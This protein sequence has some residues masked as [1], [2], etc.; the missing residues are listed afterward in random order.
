MK[1]FIFLF[2]TT[3]TFSVYAQKR[4]NVYFFR[5]DGKHITTRDSAD[6][7]RIVEEP[8]SG[9]T[10]YNVFEYYKDDK[11]KLV[12]KSSSIDPLK[13]EGQCITF[14]S[15]GKRANIINYKNGS[16]SGEEYDFYPNGK[17]YRVIDYDNENKLSPDPNGFLI[18]ENYDSLGT[19][20]V[21][22]GNGTYK[23]FDSN[24]KYINEQGK[25]KGGKRDSVWQGKFSFS[26][27][28]KR[29]FGNNDDLN[30]NKSISPFTITYVHFTENYK[31][32][33]LISGAA[34]DPDGNT[35][36]YTKG[37]QVMPEFNGGLAAFYQYLSRNIKYPA[38]D[39]KYGVQG[40]VVIQFI[41]DTA[42]AI[43]DIKLL[44]SVSPTMDA[45]AIRVLTA[46]PPWIP[47]SMFGE[48]ISTYY[49]V[50][51]TFSLAH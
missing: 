4:R 32:G 5:N 40:K 48:V 23:G 10:L 35:H 18:K 39:K 19:A 51:I 30:L 44:R 8:D 36:A 11:K 14:F 29:N 45:E 13:F 28:E 47:G 21:V 43:T 15:N 38:Q 26:G 46:S 33:K 41:V 12:G 22:D 3:L 16:K 27:D 20:L 17:R 6:Y 37:R 1:F 25:T 31:D 24:F 50:P 2:L 7:I 34:I 49:T 9:S 42:G